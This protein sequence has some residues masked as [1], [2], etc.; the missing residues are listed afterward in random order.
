LATGEIHHRRHA[1]VLG[2]SRSGLRYKRWPDTHSGY[3]WEIRAVAQA[4]ASNMAHGFVTQG[5]HIGDATRLTQLS[6][7]QTRQSQTGQRLFIG[8]LKA[9]HGVITESKFQS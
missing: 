2:Q 7:I 8:V 5:L 6:Q 3:R 9:V 1:D 4:N